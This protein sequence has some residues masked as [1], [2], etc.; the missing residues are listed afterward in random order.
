[1]NGDSETR[2]Q[3]SVGYGFAA[4]RS[5]AEMRKPGSWLVPDFHPDMVTEDDQT[6]LGD[7]ACGRGYMVSDQYHWHDFQTGVCHNRVKCV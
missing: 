5:H 6:N 7:C 3:G 4:F 1:M 2:T